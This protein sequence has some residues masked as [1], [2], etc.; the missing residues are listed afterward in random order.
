MLDFAGESDWVINYSDFSYCS[1]SH[2]VIQL[3]FHNDILQIICVY[4]FL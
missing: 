2:Y 1:Y 4:N 3:S